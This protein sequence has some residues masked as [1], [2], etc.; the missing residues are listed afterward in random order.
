MINIKCTNEEKESLIRVFN[1]S[2]ACL[3]EGFPKV[4][5]SL[6]ETNEDNEKIED[7][8]TCYKNNINWDITN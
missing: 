7:C 2:Q 6:G 1:Y 3:F 8:H 5:C 4:I